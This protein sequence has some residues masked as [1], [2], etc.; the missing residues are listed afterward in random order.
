MVCI[1][2]LF[3]SMLMHALLD[4]PM[5]LLLGLQSVYLA[6]FQGRWSTAYSFQLTLQ[7][8]KAVSFRRSMLTLML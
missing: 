2:S 7:Q 4:V 3:F 8:T 5:T 6:E 1:V